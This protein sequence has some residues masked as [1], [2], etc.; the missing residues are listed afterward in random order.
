MVALYVCVQP[1]VAAAL[2]AAFLGE[3]LGPRDLVAALLV[4]TG[5]WFA[6]VSGKARGA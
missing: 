2:A 5:V 6:S 4:F 1:L 3:S